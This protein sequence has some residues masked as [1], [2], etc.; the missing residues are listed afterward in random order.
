M[1]ML[2]FKLVGGLRQARL[3]SLLANMVQYK[4]TV[5][6]GAPGTGKTTSVMNFL[7]TAKFSFLFYSIECDKNGMVKILKASAKA[8]NISSSPLTNPAENQSILDLIEKLSEINAIAEDNKN[9]FIVFDKCRPINNTDDFSGQLQLLISKSSPN[10]HFVIIADEEPAWIQLSNKI[11]QGVFKITDEQ[12]LFTLEETGEYYKVVNEL[13]L[14]KEQINQLF[15]FTGGWVTAMEFVGRKLQKD[16]DFILSLNNDPLNAVRKL[17]E[18]SSYVDMT[19]LGSVSE[20]QK[21][22]LFAICISQEIDDDL[23]TQ[24]AGPEAAKELHKLSLMHKLISR[25]MINPDTF[26]FNRMWQCLLL[27]KAQETMGSEWLAKQ[28]DKAGSYYLDKQ[29]WKKAVYHFLES[30]SL[31]QIAFIVEQIGPRVLDN[32][33]S[34]KYYLVFNEAPLIK[35]LTNPWLQLTYAY[36]QRFKDLELCYYYLNVALE[37]FR[38][39]G[40]YKGLMQALFIKVEILM[41]YTGG[42]HKMSELINNE[43][44]GP[45][46]EDSEDLGIVGF[47]KIYIGWSHSYLTGNLKEAI[48]LGEQAKRISQLVQ[49]INL[50]IWSCWVL[51]IS[52]TYAG[53]FERAKGY[54][55]EAL[56]KISQ[57]DVEP[58]LT[59]MIPYIAGFNATYE[60]DFESAIYYMDVATDKAKEL[61]LGALDLYITNYAADAANYLGDAERAERY[62]EKMKESMRI[63]LKDDNYHVHS[64]MM[65][66]QAHHALLQDKL[67]QALGYARQALRLREEAGGEIFFIRCHLLLGTILRILG[68]YQ[69]AEVQLSTALQKSIGIESTY[70][71]A[72][73]YMQLSFLNL[74]L[75]NKNSFDD[76]V[77]K[78]LQ[79]CIDKG[80]Y[81]FYM[82]R[83]EDILKLIRLFINKTAYRGYLEMLS[84]KRGLMQNKI[85]ETRKQ[86]LTVPLINIKGLVGLRSSNA[87]LMI[88]D[89]SQKIFKLYLMGP[90]YIEQ[91]NQQITEFTSRKALYLLKILS[92]KR[93][94]ISVY[95]LI[96]EMWPDWET[97]SAMNNFY[98]TLHQLRK[99]LGNKEAITFKD[100]LCW[101]EPAF[102]WC[103]I[104]QFQA[105]IIRSKE[106]I[107]GGMGEE[108]LE[109]L[110]QTSNF[111]RGDFLE[112]EELGEILTQEREFVE[113]K[114]YAVLLLIAKLFI[115]AKRF[116]KVIEI[117]E[118]IKSSHLLDEDANR[119][120]MVAYYAQGNTKKVTELYKKLKADLYEEVK[121]SPHPLTVN[122]YDQI[123]KGEDVKKIIDWLLGEMPAELL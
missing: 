76:L 10:I 43:E 23:A 40:N 92:T 83:D 97:K 2:S 98:F 3:N 119:F 116:N 14:N 114:H 108:T 102:F 101:L 30:K 86:S 105:N 66:A 27:N 109:L 71:M 46:V 51:G 61:S 85:D 118:V 24:L 31:D 110:I 122:L 44:I 91:Y 90:F 95:R 36:S 6:C 107:K 47:K 41:F 68:D 73:S 57:P 49:D 69:G 29:H 100:G 4:V 77:S 94:P 93:G 123:I 11:Y 89:K 80:Y 13:A 60:G 21:N 112:G 54:I 96:Q 1:S 87:G 25:V 106:L 17:P 115:K 70:Y 65:A 72:S 88:G 55:A 64:F 7:Q 63:Y 62:L 19:L 42:L 34:K 121:V 28:H 8:V 81:H 39:T 22:I 16:P 111:Y 67:F 53:N 15:A 56:K 113:R 59:M 103:D 38:R 32:S 26:R 50:F 78:A 52:L 18:L 120:L 117:V 45:E 37:N 5:I 20:E 104:Q 74:A 75:G 84:E 33:A 9:F 99:N 35:I 12:L 48:R 82:W 58:A 79:L